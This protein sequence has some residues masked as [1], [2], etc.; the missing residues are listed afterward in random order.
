MRVARPLLQ[1]HPTF[2]VDPNMAHKFIILRKGKLETYTNFDDIPHDLEHVIEFSP[3]V[4]PPP[5]DEEGL[6][7]E[8]IAQWEPRLQYL[9]QLERDNAKKKVDKVG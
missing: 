4:P 9:L 2:F 3:E 1:D 5:H 8:E 7:H 6:Q